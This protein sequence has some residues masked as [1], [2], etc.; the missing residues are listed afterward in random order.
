MVP[1]AVAPLVTNLQGVLS[2]SGRSGFCQMIDRV[3]NPND[4]SLASEVSVGLAGGRASRLCRTPRSRPLSRRAPSRR[5]TPA[6]T[7]ASPRLPWTRTLWA[8]RGTTTQRVPGVMVCRSE[9]ATDPSPGSL[10]SPRSRCLGAGEPAVG[11]GEALPLPGVRVA[12]L[13]SGA[14]VCG[15]GCGLGASG[16]GGGGAP[17]AGGGG[18]VRRPGDWTCLNCHAHNFASRSVCF[19]CKNPK[20]GGSGGGGPS[21]GSGASGDLGVQGS[22]ARERP[23]GGK[24]PPG[25]LDLHRL[26]RA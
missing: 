12:R 1:E 8:R 18:G 14:L 23:H 2:T 10:A 5:P 24:L 17:P 13:T 15:F 25:R 7:C 6:R 4:W 22:G 26:P 3:A 19:K 11:G 9:R 16:K 20:A 21:F